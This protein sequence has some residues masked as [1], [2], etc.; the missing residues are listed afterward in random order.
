M[1]LTTH[2]QFEIRPCVVCGICNIQ[3]WRIL[4]IGPE[5]QILPRLKPLLSQTWITQQNGKRPTLAGRSKI[6]L[7]F[8]SP[9]IRTGKAIPRFTYHIR[10]QF[11]S[12]SYQ[13]DQSWLVI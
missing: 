13:I 11:F 2:P 8:I 5:M 3:L 10:I 12:P 1:W 7:I 6:I 4:K 9:T